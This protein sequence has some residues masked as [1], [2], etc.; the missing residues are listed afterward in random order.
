MNAIFMNSENSKRSNLH[1]LLLID[2][3]DKIDVRR[4]DWY[5][6]LSRITI[7]YTWKSIKRVI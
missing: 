6:A 3:I 7:Y 2:K 1:W 5:I 4:K